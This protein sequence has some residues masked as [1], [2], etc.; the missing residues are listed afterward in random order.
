MG[1]FSTGITIIVTT[2]IVTL[3]SA[4]AGQRRDPIMQDKLSRSVQGYPAQTPHRNLY[5]GRT[6]L[7]T[8][9]S[10]QSPPSNTSTTSID[11]L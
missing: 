6:P 8:A 1:R 3:H 2:A 4:N 5:F 7:A 10:S 9:F 11:G